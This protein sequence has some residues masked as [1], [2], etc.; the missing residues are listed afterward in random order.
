[1]KQDRGSAG[2]GI[3]IIKL[4]SEEYCA[5]YGAHVAG[6]DKVLILRVANDN[7][8]E[9]HAVT[10]FIEFYSNGA[11]TSLTSRVESDKSNRVIYEANLKYRGERSHPDPDR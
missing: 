2:E 6:V 10:E 1:M 4:K 9:A 3:W 8:V 11:L 7:H 5:S